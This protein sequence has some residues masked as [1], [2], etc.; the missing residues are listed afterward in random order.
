M[1]PTLT[2]VSIKIKY[3]GIFFYLY[4]TP[5]DWKYVLGTMYLSHCRVSAFDVRTGLHN[6]ARKSVR[7]V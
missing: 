7:S 6:S 3:N 1:T 5:F 4:K 2:I